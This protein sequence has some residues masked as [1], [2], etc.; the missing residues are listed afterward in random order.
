MS[1]YFSVFETVRSKI[2]SIPITACQYLMCTDSGD[3]FYDTKDGVRKHLTDIIDLK[4]DTERLAILAPVDKTYFVKDTAHFWRYLDGAWVD[5]S[6]AASGGSRA[7][8]AT[9]VASDWDNGQQTI[10]VD[11]LRADQNGIASL[12]Q[13][14]SSTQ[15]DAVVDAEMRVSAQSNGSLTISCFADTPKIDIPIVIILLG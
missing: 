7:I 13:A 9:L 1:N 2:D 4:T 6:A 15:Y 10:S 3:I 8:F 11:G 5:L 14:L 12:P